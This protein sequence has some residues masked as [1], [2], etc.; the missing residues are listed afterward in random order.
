MW[1]EGELKMKLMF[2]WVIHNNNCIC[3]QGCAIWQYIYRV[4]IEKHLIV[5]Y[6]DLLLISLDYKSHS[7]QQYFS[8]FGWRG[9][10]GCVVCLLGCRQEICMKATQ[11][12]M[13][14]ESERDAD[15][16]KNEE[17]VDKKRRCF[18]LMDV[19]QVWLFHVVILYKQFIHWT[20]R[21]MWFIMIFIVFWIWND[22]QYIRIWCSLKCFYKTRLKVKLGQLKW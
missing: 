12:K 15:E 4:T 19:V 3:T 22:L 13:M 14:E 21:K 7:L 2:Y 17:L 5:S 18:C 6:Y 20:Y 8:W 11:T 16:T 1:T 10:R 9:L